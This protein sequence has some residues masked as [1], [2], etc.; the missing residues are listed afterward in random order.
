ML[1]DFLDQEFRYPESLMGL[2]DF[3]EPAISLFPPIHHFAYIEVVI[4]EIEVSWCERQKF[5]LPLDLS[6]KGFR[7]Y[8]DTEVDSAIVLLMKAFVGH[9]DESQ[10]NKL[11]DMKSL[12]RLAPF[13]GAAILVLISDL[14][15]CV[16]NSL[17]QRYP[18]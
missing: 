16:T 7:R 1:F 13:Q 4:L 18:W 10:L 3:G 17:E 15:R 12:N 11:D 8:N 5:I 9:I 2:F 14:L 6:S